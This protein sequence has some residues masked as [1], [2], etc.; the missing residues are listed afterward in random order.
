[1]PGANLSATD[2]ILGSIRS[3]GGE[4]IKFVVDRCESRRQTIFARSG[5]GLLD[6]SSRDVLDAHAGLG[7]LVILTTSTYRAGVPLDRVVFVP[8]KTILWCGD[9]SAQYGDGHRRRMHTTASFGYRDTL[10]SMSTSLV[11]QLV[12]V[13]AFDFEHKQLVAGA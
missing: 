9:R 8:S 1:M 4:T 5:L 11:I 6:K 12:G 7:L 13:T 3:T 2:G 10:D